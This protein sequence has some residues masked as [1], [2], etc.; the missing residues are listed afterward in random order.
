MFS[1]GVS[2]FFGRTVLI[3]PNPKPR[4]PEAL[5]TREL[6]TKFACEFDGLV[7]DAQAAEE[8]VVG[9]YG[10]RGGGAVAIFDLPRRA[11]G[12]AVRGGSLRVV[13][14]VFACIGFQERRG[15]GRGP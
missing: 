10:A 13:N 15:E 12:T 4:S 14:V 5:A 11:S 6:R 1:T 2:T 9:A 7:L 8:Y 3:L